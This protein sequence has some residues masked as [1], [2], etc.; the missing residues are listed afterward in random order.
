[1]RVLIELADKAV[2]SL[3]SYGN[4]VLYEDELRN[5]VGIRHDLADPDGPVFLKID[6]LRRTDPPDPPAA[7]RDWL[8][9]GRDPFKE[10]IVQSL[11]TCV[12]SGADVAKLIRESSIDAADATATLKPK[13]GEDLWDVVLRLARFPE[14]KAEVQDYV[15][16][17]WR[18]WAE[19]ERPRRET[20]DIY[21]RL[22]SLQQALKLEGSDRPLEVVWGM[23]V[24]RWKLPPHELDHPIVE[25][26]V[27]LEL[28]EAGAIEVRPRGVD[29]ILALKPFTAMNNPGTDLVARFAREHFVKL[30]PERELSPFERDTFTPILRYACAQFDRAGRYHPDHASRDDRKV[31]EAGRNLVVTDTWAIYARPRSENF[32]VADLERLRE[33]VEASVSLPGPA[34]AL[35]TEPSDEPTY[36]SAVSGIPGLFGAAG[37]QPPTT[38][39][40]DIRASDGQGGIRQFFFP[41]PFN[42]EQIAI[43]ERLESPDVE[44][45]VV[46]GPPGTGKTHTIANIICHYLAT[47]RRVL[48][49][50]KSEGALTVL[51]DQIPEGIRDLAISLLTSER[52]GLKQLEATV[53]LLASKIASLD[54]RPTQ[55]DI[56]DGERRIAELERRIASID[57]EMRSFAEKHLRPVGAGEHSDGILPSELAVRIVRERDRHSWF[58]DRPRPSDPQNLKFGDADVAAARAARKALGPHLDYLAAALPSISDL[59]DAAALASIHQDLA[60][61]ARIERGRGPDAPLMSS[62]ED[63]ALARA[64]ILLVSVEALVATHEHCAEAPWLGNIFGVWRRRGLDAEP[65]R[66]FAELVAALSGPIGRRMTI[67]SYGVAAP[68]DAHTQTDLVAAVERAAAGQR[69]FAL[70]TFGKSEV[71][72][73]F[74]S[75][76]ILDRP[77]V[78]PTDW[79][80]ISQ[81]LAWRNDVAS[82][83]AR[84]RALAAEFALP[85]MPDRFDDAARLL[86]VI[87]ERV[88]IVAEAVR[89]HIPLVQSEIGRLFPYGLSAAEIAADLG[90]ARRASESIR[91]ELSRH[92]LGSA[93][94]KLSAA[95]EKL[96]TCSGRISRAMAEF[97]RQRSAIPRNQ[98]AP[99]PTDGPRSSLSWGVYGIFEHILI[100]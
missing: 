35:V 26:L 76:R 14:A 1:V 99:S 52:Q 23:G 86:Q 65:V 67:A 88:G 10:P 3:R 82:A 18:E 2:W 84:W 93:R 46:Q 8:T 11:R 68:D 42:E 85:A 24:A 31:P 28:D 20:I 48:V 58:S 38:S 79:R 27:E 75:I 50:S 71:R 30:P 7:A 19:A 62:S 57:T 54:T 44:G 92:R 55:R 51:R 61:A 47:G 60:N 97:C 100:P 69:P 16:E 90:N 78:E 87:L 15:A 74:A 17:G 96:A 34:V 41:K 40:D 33:A 49:T 70:M 73:A 83:L 94:A 21:D 43:V 80:Q 89:R 9:V 66:P 63:D 81:V 12:M 29:P 13:P 6:R 45:V 95:T 25:Q 4:V 64:E 91:T 37:V 39:I 22:F 36:T 72:A 32:F 5:R 98:R 77:P 56:G 53:N 59:P